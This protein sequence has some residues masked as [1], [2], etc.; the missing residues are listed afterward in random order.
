MGN[1]LKIIQTS[2]DQYTNPDLQMEGAETK[3]V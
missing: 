2:W 1:G 3:E